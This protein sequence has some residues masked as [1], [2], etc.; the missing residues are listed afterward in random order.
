MRIA[1]RL[2]HEIL[3]LGKPC[4]DLRDKANSGQLTPRLGTSGNLQDWA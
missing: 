4:P 3:P 1:L 2:V